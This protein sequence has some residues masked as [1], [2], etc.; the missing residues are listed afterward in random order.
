[1]PD[2]HTCSKNLE[3]VIRENI[4]KFLTM[5][6]EFDENFSKW[7]KYSTDN[8]NCTEKS[9]EHFGSKLVDPQKSLFGDI[10]LEIKYFFL[11][12]GS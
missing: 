7:S 9:F 2:F 12:L 1:M 6:T 8:K 11:K 5:S 3:F 10:S 4:C